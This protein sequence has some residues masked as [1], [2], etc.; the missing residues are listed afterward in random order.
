MSDQATPRPWSA[1]KTE[2]DYGRG[3]VGADES[4]VAYIFAGDGGDNADL[5]VRAVNAHDDLVT[6]VENFIAAWGRGDLGDPHKVIPHVRAMDAAR[7]K[8][9]AKPAAKTP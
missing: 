4:E 1:I 5:I 8:A 9:G 3:I 7:V 2:I 6:A